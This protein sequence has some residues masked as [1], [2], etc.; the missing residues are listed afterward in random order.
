MSVEIGPLGESALVE[1]FATGWLLDPNR[2]PD[3]PG[4]NWGRP[5]QVAT[6]PDGA[7]YVSSDRH[8]AIY[9]IWHAP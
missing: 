5:V 4:Q 3:Q 9:R 7:L 1:E 8:G 2:T 6:G